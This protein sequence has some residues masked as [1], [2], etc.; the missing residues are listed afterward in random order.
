MNR[1]NINDP[2]SNIDDIGDMAGNQLGLA[3]GDGI[4]DGFVCLGTSLIKGTKWYWVMPASFSCPRISRTESMKIIPMLATDY[5]ANDDAT[6]FTIHLREGIQFSDGT[7]WNA[8]AA[9]ANF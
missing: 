6:E 7:P 3:Q 2:V 5:E 9:K 1:G 4:L 8:E